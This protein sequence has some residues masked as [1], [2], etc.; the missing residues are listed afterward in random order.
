MIQPVDQLTAHT[1]RLSEIIDRLKVIRGKLAGFPSTA[2][3]E[4]LLA[5]N[6]TSILIM[7]RMLASARRDIQKTS[8]LLWP[9]G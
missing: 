8:P 9:R 4:A 7:E 3:R 6:A 1:V 5:S 2:P